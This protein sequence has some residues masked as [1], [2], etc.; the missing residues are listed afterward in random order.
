MRQWSSQS[1]F[2]EC[3]VVYYY[4]V[5]S[6]FGVPYFFHIQKNAK[7]QEK[8]GNFVRMVT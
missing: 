3:W 8:E 6:V 1:V 4:F 2:C 7:K 5:F